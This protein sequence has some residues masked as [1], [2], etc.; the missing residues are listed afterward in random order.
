[1]ENPMDEQTRVR[2]IKTGWELHREVEEHYRRHPATKSA[3]PGEPWL[4]KQRLLLADMAIHLLQ[5]ALQPGAIELDKLRNNLHAILTISDQFLP[6]A[7][8][9]GATAQIYVP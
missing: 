9:K 6:Q 5:T 8:L 7:G 1:M 2:L 3:G 4:D